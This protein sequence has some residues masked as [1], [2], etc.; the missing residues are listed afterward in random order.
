MLIVSCVVFV[1]GDELTAT[2]EVAEGEKCP[3][4]WNVRELETNAAHPELCARC[5]EVI[6]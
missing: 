3:R 2:V 5:A 1:E 6:G 4:C